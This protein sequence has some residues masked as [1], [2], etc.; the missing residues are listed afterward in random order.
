MHFFWSYNIASIEVGEQSEHKKGILPNEH[1]PQDSNDDITHVSLN[2][3]LE[4]SLSSLTSPIQKQK[5]TKTP[6]GPPR[7]N[8]L[9]SQAFGVNYDSY[10]FRYYE[11]RQSL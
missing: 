7:G 5:P 4:T 3:S 1:T 11:L 6:T 2:T 9:R 8:P 10:E